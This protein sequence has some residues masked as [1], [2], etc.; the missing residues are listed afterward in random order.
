M[1][2]KINAPGSKWHGMEGTAHADPKGGYK[3]FVDGMP[4]EL[5]DQG[6]IW[7]DWK[8]VEEIQPAKP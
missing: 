5:L 3:V 7:F 4:N 8:E 6:W 2:V 1:R